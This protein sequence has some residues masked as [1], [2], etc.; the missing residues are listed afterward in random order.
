[1]LV[2]ADPIATEGHGQKASRIMGPIIILCSKFYLAIYGVELSVHTAQTGD[3]I[4][5][6]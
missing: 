3:R 2:A 5:T 1:M 4:I 6:I